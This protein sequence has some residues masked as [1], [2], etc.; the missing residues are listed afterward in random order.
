MAN[1]VINKFNLIRFKFRL[2]NIIRPLSVEQIVIIQKELNKT[3]N[4]VLIYKKGVKRS[5]VY[6]S[7][8]KKFMCLYRNKT[9]FK[10]NYSYIKFVFFNDDYLTI[11]NDNF[12]NNDG[13]LNI[14]FIEDTFLI[15]LLYDNGFYEEQV[16]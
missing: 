1:K 10:E 15:D 16:Y 6:L 3:I 4:D 12:Y 13:K 7:S 14:Q 11:I 9:Y 8:V 2:V 5:K